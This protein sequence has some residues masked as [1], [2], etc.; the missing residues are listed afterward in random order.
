LDA[1]RAARSAEQERIEKAAREKAAAAAGR[2]LVLHQRALK[3]SKSLL[4]PVVRRFLTFA[5]QGNYSQAN[6]LLS[7]IALR[8]LD[9]ELG[10]LSGGIQGFCDK[11][12]KEGKLDEISFGAEQIRGEGGQVSYY[13]T[14]KGSPNELKGTAKLIREGGSWKVSDIY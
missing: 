2:E 5:N 9:S 3:E 4:F 14:V 1:Q 8:A 13:Y 10:A 11:V 7:S 6:Q 12:S